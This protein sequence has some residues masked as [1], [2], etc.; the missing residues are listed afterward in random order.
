MYICMPVC[1]Q[2]V[3]ICMRDF[4]GQWRYRPHETAAN[5]SGSLPLYY[6]ATR[7]DSL[8]NRHDSFICCAIVHC[9]TAFGCACC[10]LLRHSTVAVKLVARCS[11]HIQGQCGSVLSCNIWMSHVYLL[12][13]HACV[14]AICVR[15]CVNTTFRHPTR[16]YTHI[17]TYTYIH[18]YIHTH[19]HIHIYT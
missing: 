11:T 15:A 19:L 18:I 16:M 1:A 13:S 3:Y 14:S 7:H 17:H 9:H 5:G 4:R 2:Y 10:N 6:R 8:I 12:M